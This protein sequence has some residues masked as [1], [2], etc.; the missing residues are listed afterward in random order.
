MK[1]PEMPEPETPPAKTKAAEDYRRRR[2]SLPPP[3][4]PDP[5][6]LIV[7][8]RSSRKTEPD[9]AAEQYRKQRQRGL[10]PSALL[11]Y[12][13]RKFKKRVPQPKRPAVSMPD[14]PRLLH[15][16]LPDL[17][18]T[19]VEVSVV[20]GTYNR[21][22]LLQRCIES[23]RQACKEIAYEIVVCDGGSND[24]T[25]SWLKAQDDVVYIA[26]DLSGAVRAFNA[27]ARVS[28]GQFVLAV[29]DDAELDPMA[30]THGLRY[31]DD[32]FVGQV[33]LSFLEYGTWKLERVHGQIYANFALT[34]MNIIRAA[35]VIS[36]GMWATCY[37]TYGGDTELSCWVYRLGYKVVGAK[38]AKLHHREYIDDLRRKNVRTDKERIEFSRRWQHDALCFRGPLPRVSDK[39]L[40][41]LQRFE[42]GEPVDRRWPRIESVDPVFGE[43]PPR[44]T[45]R[46]ERVLHWQLRT[47]DDPQTSMVDGL[48]SLGSVGLHCVPWTEL[49]FEKRNREFVEAANAMCPSVIFLQCQ[50]AAAIS[51]D[52][53]RAVREHPRRDPS[54]VTIIWSG[55]I[56]P[57]KGPW[58]ATGDKWQY[59]FAAV[60][61]LMLFTGTGQVREHRQRGMKNAAYLQIG[62]DVDRY[63]PGPQEEYGS[64][65]ELVFMGQNYGPQFNGVPTSESQLRREVVRELQKIPGFMA[66]GSGF[67][68][69]VAQAESG[70]VYR[71]SRMALSVSLVSSLGRYSSDRLL[72]AMACGTP[73]LVKRFDDME[74][75]GLVDGANCIGWDTADELA[76]KTRYWLD[77]RRHNQLL[78]I[79][80][81]GA[82]LMRSHHTWDVRMEELQALLNAV[83]GQR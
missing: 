34:R 8:H 43:L 21:I 77:E 31:F 45:L 15:P 59:D 12:K 2:E 9:V 55:D 65:H 14:D 83:R 48:R 49:G 54:L 53:L 24:G 61:D 10:N 33:A 5:A 4:P 70:E 22:E 3:D 35:E 51:V 40:G 23:V 57:G 28:R 6:P 30:V 58:P 39:E 38:D 80:Q 72:R 17:D 16:L 75:W 37:R 74:G 26:G 11:Q 32:P 71:R 18:P 27:A 78:E 68:P 42:T 7:R 47:P 81:A 44:S 82:E 50:D 46:S 76:E 1:K 67:G 66:Y 63:Y 64:L 62:Y 41:A 60:V 29:N 20:L 56:G 13:Q 25:I 79:G 19:D 69:S 73:T 52:A 36:G